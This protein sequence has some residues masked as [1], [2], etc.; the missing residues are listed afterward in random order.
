MPITVGDGLSFCGHALSDV[1]L[2][3]IRGITREFANLTLTELAATL[4]ELLEWR[5][6]NGGLKARECYLFLRELHRRGWL[7]WLPA[8]QPRHPR[9]R[10]VAAPTP[11]PD[12]L[13]GPLEDYRPIQLQL[14]QDAAGRRLFR[15]Y[16]DRYH[17]LGYRAPYGAQLRY[18]VRSAQPGLPPLAALLFT[19]AAW[20]MAPRDRWIGWSDSVR[21]SNLPLVVNHSRFLILP[22][23]QVPHLASHILARAGKQLPGD[24]QAQYGVDPVLLETL[25][26]PA[27]YRGVCYR[28]ANWI[29]VGMTQGRG[30]MDRSGRAQGIRKQIFLYPLHRRWRQRLCTQPPTEVI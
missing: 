27:R 6:P 4:C 25:V 26:D 19:S 1:E 10:L 24:W 17:Y 30:R 22:W 13:N 23:T 7:P 16:L 21:Q 29:E 14:I 12:L 8:P 3:M 20:R 5:R 11:V 18:F 15:E 2:G 28:A 9:P